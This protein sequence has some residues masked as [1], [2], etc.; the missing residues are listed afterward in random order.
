MAVYGIV[1]SQF[2]SLPPNIDL[3]Y[4]QREELADG[5]SFADVIPMINA[6]LAAFNAEISPEVA[7]LVAPATAQI[8]VRSRFPGQFEINRNSEYDPARPQRPGKPSAH[9]LAIWVNDAAMSWTERGLAKMDAESLVAEVED[10][11]NGFRFQQFR[12]VLGRMYDPTEV[13]VDDAA[14][15]PMTSPGFA[16]SGTGGNAFAAKYFPD[17]SLIPDPYS[18]YWACTSA[19]LGVTLK[20]MRDQHRKWFKTGNFE[21]V[22][23]VAM[24][25]AIVALGEGGGFTRAERAYI[26][27]ANNVAVAQVDPNR[28]V[29]VFDND[30]FVRRPILDFTD[31]NGHLFQ[32]LG[33]LNPR[34]PLVHRFDKKT[35]KGAYVRSRGQWP[36]AQSTVLQELGVNVNNRVGVE[37]L[38]ID[39]GGVYS[40]PA[41]FSALGS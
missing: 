23:S 6:P 13:P 20:A 31:L 5:T 15:T 7:E 2:I 1:D 34:N 24:I 39:A 8:V 14:L 29:G 21:F 37:L 25:A 28:Y 4:L 19:N 12:D 27:E 33:P 9:A 35:G 32:P 22:G 16:G 38:R 30:I 3:A 26:R 41:G 17:R 11:L 36:L 10:A 40:P 18:H